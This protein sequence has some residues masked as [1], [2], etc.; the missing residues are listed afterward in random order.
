MLSTIT[1]F[2]DC[3]SSFEI[4]LQETRLH[5]SKTKIKLVL[6]DGSVIFYVKSLLKIFYVIIHIIGKKLM[7]L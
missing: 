1:L 2:T 6:K 3:I 4:L 5:L 7:A